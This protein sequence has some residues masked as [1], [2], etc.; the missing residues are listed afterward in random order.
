MRLI[1]TSLTILTFL[2]AL[3]SFSQMKVKNVFIDEEFIEIDS[4]QYSEKCK[5]HIY[6]CYGYRKD[7]IKINK[8]LN[9]YAFGQLSETELEQIKLV[10]KRDTNVIIEPN[11]SIIIKYIDSLFSF[12]SLRKK[13]DSH[14][15]K[16]KKD[17]MYYKYKPFTEKRYHSNLK[18]GTKHINKCNKKY[19][20]K[21]PVDILYMYRYAESSLKEYNHFNFFKDRNVLQHQFFKILYNYHLLI[22]KPNGNYFLS[23]VRL[24]NKYV[25]RL[26]KQDDWNPYLKDL[27]LSKLAYPNYGY[28][29]F[30]KTN[31]TIHKKTCF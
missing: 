7:T 14:G 2:I 9:K 10:L 15:K 17:N 23:G 6:K 24:N 27:K 18:K 8:V 13:Y 28:G 19:Q 31:P 16:L 30:K 1:K 5:L 21:Y 20:N 4:I 22:I 29:I 12:N 3:S 25:S 11:N 26:L